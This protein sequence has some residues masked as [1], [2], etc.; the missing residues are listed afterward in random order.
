MSKTFRLQVE[1]GAEKEILGLPPKVQRQVEA[2]L[3]RLLDTLSSGAR[4]QHVKRLKS[5]PGC[6]RINSGEYP[7]VF[8]LDATAGLITVYRVRHRKDV[9]RNL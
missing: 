4:P 2:T 1:R 7:V 8:E 9:Y 3:D 6:Y 5:E